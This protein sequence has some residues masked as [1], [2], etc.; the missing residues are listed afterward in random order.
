MKEFGR[1]KKAYRAW[2]K[3]VHVF[4]NTKKAGFRKAL[5]WA[6]KVK[7]PITQANLEATQW[8]HIAAAKSS[9]TTCSCRSAPGTR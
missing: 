4:C 1:D 3:K 8:E 9:S 6:A 5:L 7:E 2:T